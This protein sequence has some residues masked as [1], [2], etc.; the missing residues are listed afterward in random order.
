M[1]YFRMEEAAW[2]SGWP[3]LV[4]S[5]QGWREVVTSPGCDG[6][7][8][9]R[10]KVCI[11][12]RPCSGFPSPEVGSPE[13]GSGRRVVMHERLAVV[14]ELNRCWCLFVQLAT[15]GISRAEGREGHQRPV[16][17][18]LGDGLAGRSYV[19]NLAC[20]RVLRCALTSWKRACVIRRGPFGADDTWS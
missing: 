5:A 10:S 13:V 3:R 20:I 11:G 18:L 6:R 1:R 14:L 19:M 7:G 17:A 2:S 9:H 12:L 15:S 4:M 16:A 8:C